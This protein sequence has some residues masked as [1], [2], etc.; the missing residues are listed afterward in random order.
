MPKNYDSDPCDPYAIEFNAIPI[1]TIYKARLVTKGYTQTYGMDYLETL[2]PI[3]KLN[4]VRV[5]LSLA[6]NYDWPLLLF[7]V[8]HCDLNEGIYMDLPH[9][10]QNLQKYLASKFE[11]KSLGDLLLIGIEV[12]R[13]KHGFFLSQRKY[14][15]D[16]LAETE[17]LDCK[18]NDIPSQ[19]NHKLGLYPDQVPTD[20]ERYQRLVRKLIYLTHTRLD[21]TYTMSVMSKFMH[22]PSKDHMGAVIRILRYLNIV[23]WLK[24]IEVDRHFIKEKLDAK[25]FSFP[26]ISSKYQLMDVLKKVVYSIAFLNSLDKLGIHDIFA[27]T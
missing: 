21:I 16:L 22:F 27:P 23:G 1:S 7:D 9:G 3:A 17:M 26:F 12:V 15:L 13:S 4:T 18:Q 20:K 10:M 19:Q 25:I 14:V 5:L 2:A 8:I 6:T 11:M 24:H